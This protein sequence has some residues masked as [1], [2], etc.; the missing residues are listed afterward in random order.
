MCEQMQARILCALQTVGKPAEG[1]GGGTLC[2]AAWRG[3]GLLCRPHRSQVPDPRSSFW[4]VNSGTDVGTWGP[5]R[6]RPSRAADAGP[7][8]HGAE[9]HSL[10]FSPEGPVSFRRLITAVCVHACVF[11]GVFF[12]CTLLV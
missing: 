1:V 4:A 3:K 11:G 8:E 6:G 10:L 12:K 5:G 9:E 7:G 2:Q